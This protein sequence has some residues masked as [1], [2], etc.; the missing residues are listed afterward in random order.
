M[1]ESYGTISGLRS[2]LHGCRGRW[3]CRSKFHPQPAIDYSVSALLLG[4]KKLLKTAWRALSVARRLQLAV[5]G[6]SIGRCYAFNWSDDNSITLQA[7]MYLRGSKGR[8]VE[9]L[10]DTRVVMIS[11]PRQSGKTTLAKQIA[12]RGMPY[13]SLDDA[14]TLAAATHDPVAFVRGLDRAVIDEIQRAPDLLLP[15]KQSVDT[16]K[17]PGRFLLT[18]SANLMTLPRIADSLAGR[19][20]VV[21]L[22]PLAQ[23][24]I[25][26][27]S[28]PFLDTVFSGKPPS[29][30]EL[31]LGQDLVTTVLAGGYPE[32]LTRSNWTRRRDW[33][34]DYVDSII[35]R[36]VRDIA[37]IERLKQMPRLLR[38][39]AQHGAQL[40]NYS[41]IG[42]AVNLPHVTTRKYVDIFEQL[43]LMTT[44]QP[45][46]TNTLSRL[47]K[48][49]K[50]HFL[51]SGLLAALKDLSSERL[52][53]D[54]TQFG[55]LLETFVLS[56]LFKLASW[57]DNR[58]QFFHFRDKDKNEVDI[59]MEDLQGRVVGIEVKAAAT[60]TAKDFSGLEKLKRAC[61]KKFVLGLVLYDHDQL[62]SFGEQMY[63]AP[64]SALWGE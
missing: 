9:A 53:A 19:M 31:I 54:R 62:L 20:S 51:D 41:R 24:E 50:V 26:S 17:R 13:F 4:R 40:V 58:F 45:W 55:P 29:V 27:V 3:N 43:F 56:E 15:I 38:I 11:G 28:S 49:P 44:L 23:T 60:A 14:A 22:Y 59:V 46:F 12:T 37:D 10:R 18:G 32:A 61:G 47:I 63:A 34:L 2:D 48:T 6:L 7:L 25:R 52:R 16:D 35:Q 64:I 57:S 5:I 1:L 42:A 21:R 39:L 36:D 30:G 33:Y 8:L